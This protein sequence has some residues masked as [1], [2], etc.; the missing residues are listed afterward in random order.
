MHIQ[1]RLL[2]QPGVISPPGADL[3]LGKPFAL[4]VYLIDHGPATRDHLAE[5]LWSGSERSRA[6][7]SVRQAIWLL[8]QRLGE[9]VFDGE[10]PI[11]LD[12]TVL[13]TD[14]EDLIALLASESADPAAVEPLL[15]EPLEGLTVA[16]A[17]VW[18]LWAED[19]RSRT[20]HRIGSRLRHLAEQAAAEGDVTQSC[21]FLRLALRIQPE[22]AETYLALV[23]HLLDLRELDE[24]ESQIDAVRQLGDPEAV[25]LLEPWEERL[26]ALRLS[27]VPTGRA[28]IRLDFVG[29]SREISKLVGQ[30]RLAARGQGQ[31]AVI[32]GPAGIGKTRLVE[33]MA[34]VAQLD[35]VQVVQA[36]AHESE[37]NIRFGAITDLVRELLSLRGSAGISAASDDA[38]RA[39]VPSLSGN[40]GMRTVDPSRALS[41]S[42]ADAFLDLLD[43]VSNE[44]P[45]LLIVEDLHWADDDSRA[46]LSRTARRTSSTSSLVIVTSRDGNDPALTRALS[47]LRAPEHAA[48]VA[49]RPLD[50][51]DT[52]ELL[53]LL[54]DFGSAGEL[55]AMA[56]RLHT[57]SGGN[58]LFLLET[59]RTLQDRHLLAAGEEGRWHFLDVDPSALELAPTLRDMLIRRVEQLPDEAREVAAKLAR[60]GRPRSLWELDIGPGEDRA[61]APLLEAGVV[62]WTEDGRSVDFL[63][64][65]L[66]DAVRARVPGVARRRTWLWVAGSASAAVLAWAVATTPLGI[67]HAPAPWGGGT[68]WA[69][70]DGVFRVYR[71]VDDPPGWDID[72]TLA[73]PQLDLRPFRAAPDRLVWLG[74][75]TYLDDAPD[76]VML[77]PDGSE[78]VLMQRASD[79]IAV[80]ISP[81]GRTTLV[82]SDDPEIPGYVLDTWL[83]S[84]DGG[85]AT[86]LRR[87]ARAP[88]WAPDGLRILAASPGP[89]DTVR[90][91][92][93]D[94]R[95]EVEHI[96]P[97]FHTTGWCGP[98]HVFVLDRWTSEPR[99]TLV[100]VE[101]RTQEIDVG[102][103]PGLP[104]LQCSPDGSAL[105]YWVARGG[106]LE[107]VLQPLPTGEI[108]PTGVPVSTYMTWLPDSVGPVPRDVRVE[109]DTA[110]VEWG[111][112]LPLSATVHYTDGSRRPFALEWRS[113]DDNVA[114]VG[115]TGIVA[116]NNIG[117]TEIVVSV[118]GWHHDTTT[119]VVAGADRSVT[120]FQDDLSAVDLDR[121]HLLGLPTPV[122]RIVDGDTVLHLNG[123]G[124]YSDGVITRAP[125]D[126]STGLT[127]EVEFRM[128]LSRPDRQRLDL[129]LDDADPPADSVATRDWAA[130][131]RRS[132]WCFR[133]PA[134][135]LSEFDS[136]VASLHSGPALELF[137]VGAFLPSNEWVHLAL[138]VRPDGYAALYLNR[139]HIGTSQLRIVDF[140]DR[141]WRVQLRG[142]SVDTELLVRDLVVWP[143]A[144]YR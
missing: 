131:S 64:D 9:A 81:D 93:P 43:A 117:T 67:R 39:M 11:G 47:A 40:G 25:R 89:P 44:A 7:A 119:V 78:H 16:D 116:G 126:V 83:I 98:D 34:M 105:M 42:L 134:L 106:A 22:R 92:R 10:D 28:E 17:P 50:R 66:R 56:D 142:A 35:G 85:E 4:L 135:E 137:D 97:E 33:E 23:S 26:R 51:A 129:C 41:A 104:R 70:N 132:H 61:L 31:I 12:P 49:L 74:Q 68:V 102:I 95:V 3:P 71:P 24:A 58:P 79:D 96:A 109:V 63:H 86:L 128:P 72:T 87:R 94:G 144:R 111:G 143:R 75:R 108:R 2:G 133:Y 32:T 124:R 121:W 55:R 54:A 110:R 38:L 80:G 140:N 57:V 88:A 6:R 48:T 45:L 37:R 13:E 118:A 5:V 139:Q 46:L 53:G 91:L 1:V 125:L 127:A 36:K 107:G 138:Q 21:A 100:D 112:N 77:R 60:A 76:A 122:S 101:G 59:L 15:G 27:Q 82:L 18:R 73:P 8:R 136:T 90:L 69:W 19:F 30:L 84:V 120:L 99:F 65:E 141:Q 29:R 52:E 123:D 20:A 115:P 114:S 62:G 103:M 113:L 130:W 14:L